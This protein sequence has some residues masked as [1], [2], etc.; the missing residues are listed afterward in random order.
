MFRIVEARTVGLNIRQLTVQAPRIARKQR[1][2]QFII[3][4]VHAMGERIPLTIKSADPAAGTITIVVQAVG[5]TTSLLNCLET[6]DSILDVVGPLGHPSEIKNYGTALIV[7]GSVGTAMALPTAKALKDAGNHVIFIEGARSKDMVI[8]EDEVRAA[9]HEAYILTDDGS[10]GEQGLVT[11]KLSDLVD[12]G[13]GAGRKIDFVL[14]VG[15]VPM[16]RAVAHVTAPLGIKTMVS[17][18][19]IMVDG[20]GMCG[21]CRVLLGNQS[22]FACVDGPEF[23]ASQVNFEVLMQRNA[24]YR[25]QECQ[26]LKAFEEHKQEQ[27]THQRASLAHKEKQTAPQRA[28]LDAVRTTSE[29]KHNA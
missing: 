4:R 21:G 24:M 10:Y 18:N 5:K 14:A 9:S 7:A 27:L 8:F 11:K 3:L 25:G 17:L 1:P 28:Q 29:E 26:S 6:G 13:P 20:T 23:D 2:G 19:S 16:M 12:N 22:K 15:P